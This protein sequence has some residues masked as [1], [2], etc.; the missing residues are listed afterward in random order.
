MFT[1]TV[2]LQDGTIDQVSLESG[3][4]VLPITSIGVHV[5]RDSIRISNGT[6]PN[7][8]GAIYYKSIVLTHDTARFAILP[9]KS[10]FASNRIFV[11]IADGNHLLRPR[12]IIE[13]RFGLYTNPTER[14]AA[15]RAIR[16]QDLVIP[17]V[18]ENF[19]PTYSRMPRVSRAHYKRLYNGRSATLIKNRADG[20]PT[21]LENM[22][23]TRWVGPYHFDG[24][25]SAYEP[26]G[27]GIDSTCA[28][29]EQCN[30]AVLFKS[31][32]H[33]ASIARAFV[34]CYDRVTGNPVSI[35]DARLQ[36]VQ[37]TGELT[38]ARWRM[39]MEPF[40]EAG[41]GGS[42]YDL[43]YKRF[44]VGTC[45]YED[46]LWEFDTEDSGHLPRA[47][48]N[49][50]S[51]VE[52]AKDQLCADD[53]WMLGENVRQREWSDLPTES[54]GGEYVP[55]SLTAA[56]AYPVGYGH[57]RLD[58]YWAWPAFLGATCH[59]YGRGNWVGWMTNMLQLSTNSLDKFSICGRAQDQSTGAFPPGYTG[60]MTFH[61]G[62]V[63][64]ARA[65]L[66]MA[67]GTPTNSL[68]ETCNSLYNVL[69]PVPYGDLFIGPAHW[70][71]TSW[72]NADLDAIQGFGPGD[73]AHLLAAIALSYRMTGNPE[74]LSMALKHVV[75]HD[76]NY[77]RLVWLRSLENMEKA[78]GCEM[79]ALLE[80]LQE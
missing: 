26:G 29:Y 35:Y 57:P 72:N 51:V 71:A 49:G 41:P 44:N 47:I 30:E 73:P 14:I 55:P 56:L 17:P 45:P 59:K 7:P 70:T 15:F 3:W 76:N 65:T 1:L 13:R 18:V 23:N 77:D 68:F 42:Y 21:Y 53:L 64:I 12:Q 52:Y 80:H 32:M 20:L 8:P 61:E 39:E 6:F 27:Y 10:S 50:I 63:I 74:L 31:I 62:L 60:C 19:G 69:E 75:P 9:Q 33:E 67:L 38:Q 58:R 16:F 4:A 66:M 24:M 22:A 28:G 11:I 78:W 5:Y 2:T 54:T 43:R 46:Q 37:L 25:P 34:A 48:R 40:T 79:E 36:F